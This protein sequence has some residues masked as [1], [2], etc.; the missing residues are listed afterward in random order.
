M[1]VFVGIKLFEPN[2]LEAFK[3]SVNN[4][5]LNRIKWVKKENL[6]LTL[7]FIG[8]IETHKIE[9]LKNAIHLIVQQHQPLKVN[10]N[11]SG[12]FKKKRKNSILWFKV[13][14]N[15]GLISLQKDLLEAVKSVFPQF[16]DEYKTYTPHITVGRCSRDIIITE[17][18]YDSI[19]ETQTINEIQLIESCTT[20]NGVEYKI[21]E[22]FKM[23]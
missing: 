8:S 15:T 2:S 16:L 9:P 22:L 4:Q 21:I 20:S 7:V 14:M 19:N 10:I 12:L 6:H 17:Q 3:S 1:R 5:Y 18:L 11:G 13:N 23:I